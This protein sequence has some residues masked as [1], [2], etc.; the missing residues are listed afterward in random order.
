MSPDNHRPKKKPKRKASDAKPDFRFINHDLSAEQQEDLAGYAEALEW[1]GSVVDKLV[2]EGYAYKLAI[3]PQGRGFRAHFIDTVNVSPYYNVCLSGRGS[4]P[5]DARYALLY[6]H[7][8]L[9]ADGW[10]VLDSGEDTP[11]RFG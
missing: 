2:E 3:D 5:F 10:H 1:D 11:S 6:R 7:L 4:T 8:V 9:A